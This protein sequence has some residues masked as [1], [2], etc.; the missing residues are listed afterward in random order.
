[1]SFAIE[2]VAVEGDLVA[3]SGTMSGRHTG[4]FVTWNADAQVERVFVATGKTFTV[5]H[6]HFH[7]MRDGLI[8]EHW[9]VRDDMGQ[10]TQLGWVPPS[11]LYLWRCSRATRRAAKG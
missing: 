7:R 1:M 6:A 8:A 3:W 4:D 11:P 5:P 2:H 10:A 9:A